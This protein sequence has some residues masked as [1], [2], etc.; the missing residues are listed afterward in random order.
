MENIEFTISHALSDTENYDQELFELLEPNI[1]AAIE[2]A[3]EGGVTP[4]PN[5]EIF[6]MHEND[7]NETQIE[8]NF[9]IVGRTLFET[10]V[11]FS[12]ILD[13]DEEMNAYGLNVQNYDEVE[14]I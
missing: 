11:D 2:K 14:N 9:I 12:V 8:G 13:S 3:I 6:V 4:V 1:E 7:D 5:D 10:H